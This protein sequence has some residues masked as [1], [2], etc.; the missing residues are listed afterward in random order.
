M[1]VFRAL[2]LCLV[3]VDG[4]TQAPPI[5]P[6]PTVGS[7]IVS[8][9]V[10]STGSSPQPIRRAVIKLSTGGNVSRGAITDD[11]GQFTIGSLP[12]GNYTLTVSKPAYLTTT[13]GA[14]GGVGTTIVLKDGERLGNL[15]VPLT[16]GSVIT[17]TVRDQ[18]GEPARDVPVYVTRK[19]IPPPAP[20][21]GVSTNIPTVVT[22]DTGTYRVYGLTAGTYL[23][24]ALPR[25]SVGGNEIAT[26][27][28]AQVDA[29]LRLL[30][31]RS[32]TVGA[33]PV[34]QTPPAASTDRRVNFTPVFHPAA[35]DFEQATP[36]VVGAG[37]ERRG[38]DISIVLVPVATVSGIVIG[39]DGQ[40]TS[41]VSVEL[42][43]PLPLMPL[44][45]SLDLNLQRR[46]ATDGTFRFTGVMPGTYTL[47]A[48][49]TAQVT[50]YSETGQVLGSTGGLNDIPAGTFYLASTKIEVGG[51]NELS[52]LVLRLVPG[53]R[54]T[55]KIVFD[56]TTQPAPA[57]M[58]AIRLTM[59]SESETQ[60]AM[61]ILLG[62]QTAATTIN[63]DG[64]FEIRG[65]TPGAYTFAAT[66]PPGA[67]QKPWMLR[68]ALMGDR[69][70]LDHPMEV[71][72]TDLS[73][74]GITFTDRHTELSGTLATAAGVPVSDYVIVAMPADR[75]LWRSARRVQSARPS[76][77]GQ[78]TFTDLP[79]GD[80]LLATLTDIPE[81]WKTVEFLG[82]IA[83]AGTKLSI[84]EGEKK[85]FN[86]QIAR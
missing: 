1:T 15:R 42:S 22:D 68:S 10:V 45:A 75:A 46:P 9:V 56:A 40:P 5:S 59:T 26:M 36:V 44:S 24:G 84:G 73:D 54:M 61:R 79:P 17:G 14:K 33:P 49:S 16:K 52:G 43:R 76:T 18:L 58:S 39:P 47:L 19:G 28:R 66:I 29:E 35:I 51:G 62:S 86:L 50:R 72:D 25:P 37:E 32:G 41:A 20:G 57:N 55:G 70:L 81:N 34:T 69:D 7:A 80:Y 3:L 30:Q 74:I 23:V 2:A 63:P 6:P 60:S 64:T 82:S 8:G 78:F 11:S 48:K 21:L 31:Q 71:G 13:F 27:T 4:V 85:V 77:T 12:A 83:G 65:L 38:I 67:A 53:P